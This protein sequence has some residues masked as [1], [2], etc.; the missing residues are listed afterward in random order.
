MCV[1]YICEKLTGGET[2]WKQSSSLE[3]YRLG[4]W[5]FSNGADKSSARGKVLESFVIE[6]KQ[7]FDQFEKTRAPI[8]SV[9]S[10]SRTL[11][12]CLEPKFLHKMAFQIAKIILLPSLETTL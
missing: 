9:N 6:G 3:L 10:I 2:E 7:L 8:P 1:I 5:I 11:W 12:P 4:R